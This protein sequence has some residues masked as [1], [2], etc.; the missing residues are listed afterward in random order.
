[1]CKRVCVCLLLGLT[2]QNV[3]SCH[4]S[5]RSRGCG[6]G[7]VGHISKKRLPAAHGASQ[8]RLWGERATP[9]HA[10]ISDWSE[11]SKEKKGRSIERRVKWEV[12]WILE[13]YKYRTQG[14]TVTLVNRW[15]LH[16]Q[17]FTYS[18]L[19]GGKLQS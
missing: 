6:G 18:I 11:Q 7:G 8:N 17:S 10:V 9:P 3:P 15:T 2:V 14:L 16:G 5:G 4:A 12:Y 13:I 1:M 19:S